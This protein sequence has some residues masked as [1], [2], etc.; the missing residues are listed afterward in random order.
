MKPLILSVNKSSK[1]FLSDKHQTWYADQVAAQLS[2]KIAPHDLKLDVRLLVVKPLHAKWVA[3][4]HH[5]MQLSAGKKIIQNGFLKGHVKEP[6]DQAIAHQNCA[7]N[8]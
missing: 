4:F 1:Y 5:H 7:E 2:C 8:L 3:Q 6:F